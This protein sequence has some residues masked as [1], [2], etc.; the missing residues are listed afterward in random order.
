M[1]LARLRDAEGRG[2]EAAEHLARAL[3][4]AP[5]D[6]TVVYWAASIAGRAEARAHLAH[7]LALARGDDPQRVEAARGSLA[8]LSALGDMPVWLTAQRPASVRLPLTLVWDEDERG[9]ARMGRSKHGSARRRD[10]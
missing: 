9:H 5:D 1:T 10:R 3:A 6:P 2:A 7:Y 4:A 8:V